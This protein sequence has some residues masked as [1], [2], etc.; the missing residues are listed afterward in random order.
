MA[1]RQQRQVGQARAARW[2][3][4]QG[5]RS[6]HWRRSQQQQQQ[7]RLKQA[8]LQGLWSQHWRQSQQQQQQ[9]RWE[10][11]SIHFRRRLRQIPCRRLDKTSNRRGRLF[12]Q[13]PSQQQRRGGHAQEPSQQQR[14]GGHRKRRRQHLRRQC[15]HLRSQHL[16]QP[17][18]PLESA[19][20]LR[21]QKSESSHHSQQ[22]Q[23]RQLPEEVKLIKLSVRPLQLLKILMSSWTESNRCSALM[24]PILGLPNSSDQQLQRPRDQVQ[25][26]QVHQQ[27]SQH[28]QQQQLNRSLR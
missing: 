5:H 17:E 21:N 23:Q 22:Q 8:R 9:H 14:R 16:L 11:E 28:H 6:L 13:Q 3:P 27:R 24:R 15:P 26:Q 18:Q 7:H 1:F 19:K 2:R 25:Q 12:A 10:E 20:Q 4:L